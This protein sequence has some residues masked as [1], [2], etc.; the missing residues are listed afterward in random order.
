MALEYLKLSLL[1]E[2]QKPQGWVLVDEEIKML[3]NDDIPTFSIAC[4]DNEIILFTG[5]H[6]KL[7]CGIEIAQSR[8]RRLSQSFIE[9]QVELINASCHFEEGEKGKPIER[10]QTQ[11]LSLPFQK[12]QLII[13]CQ[14]KISLLSSRELHGC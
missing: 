4:G 1:H 14:D 13:L 12:M 6:V 9:Y 8:L 11:T 7:R 2:K 3:F 5:E 10:I